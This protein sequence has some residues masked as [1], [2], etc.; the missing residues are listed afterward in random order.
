MAQIDEKLNDYS[1]FHQF[2]AN[3]P[4]HAKSFFSHIYSSKPNP[5]LFHYNSDTDISSVFSK[6]SITKISASTVWL[7]SASS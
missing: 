7:I 6:E 2:S 1:L 4:H 5:I 3:K